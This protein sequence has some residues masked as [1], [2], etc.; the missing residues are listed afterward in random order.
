MSRASPMERLMLSLINKEREARGLDPLQLE[1]NL[2]ESAE[3][4]SDW[5]GRTNKFS[6]TGAKGSNA[7]ER[8]EDAGFKFQ[9][10]SAW[11]ENLAFVSLDNKSGLESEVRQMHQNLMNSPSHK[12]NILNPDLEYIG[13][14]IVRGP[15]NGHSGVFVTQNFAKTAGPVLLNNGYLTGTSGNDTL[16]G[17]KRNDK[18]DGADG[19]DTLRGK[20]GN[21]TL[22]G[23]NNDDTL[24]GQLDHDRMY[25]GAGDDELLG[26]KGKDKLYGGGG[27]DRLVGGDGSDRLSGGDGSDLL[28]GG[29]GADDFIFTAGVDT[30]QDFGR[31]ADQVS[32]AGVDEITS[33]KD[34]RDNHMQQSGDDVH[35]SDGNGNVMIL[36]DVLLSELDRD[37]FIL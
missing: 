11:A 16:N 4:H 32:L 19:N 12:A 15:Y 18:I 33:F 22:K 23:G 30:V 29:T 37:D 34:L 25:G 27:D 35:V 8:M 13:I 10:S 7:G 31:G 24:Y 20:N 14:G 26:G 9:G 21:D 28:I 2:N 6:H 3:D 17:R 5:M 1:Q 36:E